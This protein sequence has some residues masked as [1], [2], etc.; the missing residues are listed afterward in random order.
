MTGALTS[1]VDVAAIALSVLVALDFRGW[2]SRAARFVGRFM[3]IG[4]LGGAGGLGGLV[5]SLIVRGGAVWVATASLSQVVA[6]T[7]VH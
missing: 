4:V 1:V 7:L 5:A 2:A 3:L 6:A